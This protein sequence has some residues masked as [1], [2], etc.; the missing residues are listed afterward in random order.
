MS[1]E[2]GFKHALESRLA[3]LFAGT[4]IS[5]TLGQKRA[6]RM[7]EFGLVG[8][9]AAATNFATLIA[10]LTQVE[11]A[12]A[13]TL[14]FLC[15]ITVA[16]NGNRKLTFDNPPGCV[17]RQYARYVGVNLG[18]YAVYMTSLWVAVNLLLL[19]F[20]VAGLLAIGAGGIL[21]F[22]GSIEY[23]FKTAGN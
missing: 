17:Y 21:N 19:P 13:G 10:A 16:F 1:D 20:A 3:A 9:I 6:V 14:A 7:V 8:L 22:F 4:I 2:D 23:A 5:R 12:I 11:Y 15:G 18:G